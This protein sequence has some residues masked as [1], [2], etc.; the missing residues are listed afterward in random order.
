MAGEQEGFTQTSQLQ[1]LALTTGHQPPSSMERQLC[2][3]S[4]AVLQCGLKLSTGYAGEEN[5]S[6]RG[7]LGLP[8]MKIKSHSRCNLVAL[9]G[10]GVAIPSSGECP[11]P[12]S[13]VSFIRG[14][15]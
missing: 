1:G 9:V 6:Q 12:F 5:F 14:G 11:Q 7:P 8:Q 15:K 10:K 4:V 2:R 13:D 3:G